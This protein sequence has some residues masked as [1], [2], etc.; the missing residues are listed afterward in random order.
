MWWCENLFIQGLVQWT[1][2]VDKGTGARAD[3]L[4]SA[5]IVA[6]GTIH[7]TLPRGR[8]LLR[9]IGGGRH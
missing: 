2:L 4:R 6:E 5:A 8:L 1:V 7:A 9:A 3:P